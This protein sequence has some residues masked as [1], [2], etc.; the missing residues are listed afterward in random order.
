MTRV[1]LGLEGFCVS[2]ANVSDRIVH[3]S[4]RIHFRERQTSCHVTLSKEKVAILF[5]ASMFCVRPPS[6]EE[7][8]QMLALLE[9][10]SHTTEPG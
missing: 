3:G 6:E 1:R 10:K 8:D 2:D 5:A 9:S 4:F 7:I